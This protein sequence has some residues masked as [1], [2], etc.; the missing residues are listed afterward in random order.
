MTETIPAPH[1]GSH[2]RADD[3]V[4]T[5]T[6]QSGAGA[7]ARALD[8]ARV[9]LYEATAHAPRVLGTATTDA[10]GRFSLQH[11]HSEAGSI[12]YVTASAG[13]RV[14]LAAII[15]PEM[16][17]FVTL[18]EL[19]TVAAAFSTAQFIELSE[20][21]GNAF[22]LRIA[23]GMNDNLV[24]P[25]TGE[26]SE[27]M[28]ASPNADETNS[29]RST[30]GLANLLAGCVRGEPGAL[31]RVLALTTPPHGPAPDD[32][33]QAIV[34]I[35]RH[36]ANNVAGIY[37]QA[38]AVEI[39]TPALENLPDAW[40]LVVK[41]NDS[42][43]VNRMFGGPA[44]IAFDRNGY[45]WV[46]NNVVQG[47]PNSAQWIM[48]LKP[49]GKA[50]DGRNGTPMSPVSGGGTFGVGFGITVAP[51]GHVWAG[52]FGWGD[53]DTYYPVDGTVSK[54]DALG[55]PVSPPQGYGGGTDRVQATVADRDG[56]I[57]L[58]SFGNN[59]LVVFPGGDPTAAVI[60]PDAGGTAG[61][62]GTFGIAIADDGSAWVAYSGGLGWPR[63]KQSPSH[64]CR[65]RLVDG[66]LERT[67][68]LEL[69]DVTKGVA[70]D[71]AHNAWVASGGDDTVYMIS[72]DGRTVTGFQGGGITG[73]W[74]VAVDGDDNVWV[75]NFGTMGPAH[76]YTDA[77][78]S[79]I[80][81]IHPP[82]GYRT[83]DPISPERGYTLPSAG[84]PVRLPDGELLYGPGS[85]PCYSP[86]MRQTSC[87]IDQAGNVWAVN[88]WKPNFATDFLPDTGN[89]GGDG[90]CIFVGVAGPPKPKH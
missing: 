58:A 43:D 88:N 28:L 23:A 33:F 42:G 16:R 84:S 55:R 32:T 77:A 50:A 25:L 19:T 69:G 74:S 38:Q 78:L 13:D 62:I 41:V 63:E 56:N 71:S 60:Y 70:L 20:I 57:W 82:A 40:T 11:T 39:Y 5:G 81:G 66:K 45:A 73:P 51:D 46:A 31:D 52:N 37:T 10:A 87:T 47:T 21:A 49:D 22:G 4:L 72:P 35:A 44:N 76:D 30:R 64:V 75:A 1:P 65:F 83:G 53:P 34:N 68:D 67:L 85:E 15:G 18:N 7:G 90:I 36:P 17:S 48:V 8:G 14:T 29:L 6:V 89:P 61:P 80:A 12:F 27:V 3:R 86:L 59:A 54:F 2:A 26:P 24:S 9:T 79:K